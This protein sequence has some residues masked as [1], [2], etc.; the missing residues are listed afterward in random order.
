MNHFDTIIDERS[1][2]L[3]VYCYNGTTPVLS[4]FFSSF[5]FHQ[6]I[7]SSLAQCLALYSSYDALHPTVCRFQ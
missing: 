6:S 4:S 1:M 5:Q 2:V 7:T 3:V